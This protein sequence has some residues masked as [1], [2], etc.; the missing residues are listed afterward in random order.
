MV[1][2][3]RGLTRHCSRARI[4]AHAARIRRRAYPALVHVR[5]HRYSQS[6]KRDEGKSDARPEDRGRAIG[7][8]S[9]DRGIS[10]RIDADKPGPHY[11]LA[12]EHSNYRG[13]GML[14][15]RTD[16][17]FPDRRSVSGYV[18]IC[19]KASPPRLLLQG[20]YITSYGEVTFWAI[21]IPHKDSFVL[22]NLLYIVTSRFSFFFLFGKESS[23]NR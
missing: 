6:R 14:L 12:K 9:S 8:R 13:S 20:E 21:C 3:G 22:P 17:A 11:F 19:N 4:R 15:L 2:Q 18:R 5:R 7:G 10:N 1:R 16:T 23:K